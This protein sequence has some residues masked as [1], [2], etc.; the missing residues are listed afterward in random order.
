M[1]YQEYKVSI[2]KSNGDIASKM[3]DATSTDHAKEEGQRYGR[4]LRAVPITP[5]RFRTV[6]FSLRETISRL[7][8]CGKLS[9]NRFS[10]ANR[11]DFL[12]TFANMLVGYNINDA[13]SIMIQNFKGPIRDACRKIQYKCMVQQQ[14]PVDA[15]QGIGHK[16]FPGVTMAIIRSNAQVSSIDVAFREGLVFEREISKLQTGHVLKVIMAMIWFVGTIIAVVGFQ[17]FG[18]DLLDGM[19]YFAMMPKEG[20]SVDLLNTT[21]ELMGYANVFAII[22]GSAWLGVFV[23]IGAGRDIS[24][25]KMEKFILKLPLLRGAML[26]KNS[27]VACYQIEKLMSKGVTQTEAFTHVRNELEDGVLKDDLERVLNL[28]KEGS[29]DWVDGFH[30]FT[31]MDRALLKSSNS[32][33]EMAEVFGAQANQFLISYQR[34]IDHLNILHW[35]FISGFMLVLISALSI[36]MFLPMIGGFEMVSEL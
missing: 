22:L 30:S 26:N 2:R 20:K 19:N 21:R 8:L 25:A 28:I 27:F 32:S 15:V 5:S 18:W 7:P 12:Q 10:S 35:F 13:L 31:D 4:V 17:V 36:L 1:E 33:D 34:S 23:F 29:P 24:P 16:Y 6:M 11:I 3:I 14:D 9:R